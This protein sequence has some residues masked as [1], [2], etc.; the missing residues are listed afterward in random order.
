MGAPPLA[1]S[2]PTGLT[3]HNFRFDRYGVRVPAIVISPTCGRRR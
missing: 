1:A 3:R 2:H